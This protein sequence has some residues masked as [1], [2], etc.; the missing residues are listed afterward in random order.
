[1]PTPSNEA[2]I[3]ALIIERELLK[4]ARDRQGNGFGRNDYTRMIA[5]L[6]A[7]IRYY[8]KKASPAP[9]HHWFMFALF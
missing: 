2:A 4:D 5:R 6:Q 8:I 9:E 7:S 3:N 1:M